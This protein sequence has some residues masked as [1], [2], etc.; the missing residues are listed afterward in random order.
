MIS[1]SC[2]ELQKLEIVSVQ[3]FKADTNQTSIF[4]LS[5]S[6]CKVCLF[7]NPLPSLDH[8]QEILSQFVYVF[9][10]LPDDKFLT[11]PN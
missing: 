10:S 11:L 5:C 1:L 2:K 7:L 3:L 6:S 8:Y 4:S 9:N